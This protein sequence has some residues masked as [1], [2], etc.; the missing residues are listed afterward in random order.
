MKR[1]NVVVIPPVVEEGVIM[2]KNNKY[3][4]SRSKEFQGVSYSPGMT[5]E[6]PKDVTVP[7][8]FRP[9]S[10]GPFSFCLKECFR[11][12][13]QFKPGDIWD[14]QNLPAPDNI[15]APVADREKYECLESN[16][17]VMTLKRSAPP[18]PPYTK[19]PD[20]R[21]KPKSQGEYTP[22]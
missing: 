7:G 8:E 9:I 20:E 13:R 22:I 17:W 18:S 3:M 10:Q 12:G 1:K 2:K 14:F 6:F 15:F 11:N 21:M 5:V 19:V 4:V 16:G